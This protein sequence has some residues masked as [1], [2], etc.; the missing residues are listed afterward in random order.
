MVCQR[1]SAL[2]MMVHACAALDCVISLAQ[3]AREYNWCRPQLI[4]ESVIDVDSSR[5]P[6]S[7]LLSNSRFVANPIR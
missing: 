6:I 3:A 5:H 4:A 2:L 1:R 7:E